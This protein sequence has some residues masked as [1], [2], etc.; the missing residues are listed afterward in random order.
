MAG[1]DRKN[2]DESLVTS[3][4][5]GLTVREAAQKAKISERT[6]YRRLEDAEFRARVHEAPKQM[7]ERTLSVV[8]SAGVLA[9]Q[10]LR[11]LLNANSESV[12]LGAS[13]ALLEL[14]S[15]LRENIEL[16]ERLTALEQLLEKGS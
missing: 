15:R 9:A 6:V 7:F 2:A 11:T 16:D 1:G 4:A 8:A 5:S 12:Q 14:G 13:R 10:T 3:P